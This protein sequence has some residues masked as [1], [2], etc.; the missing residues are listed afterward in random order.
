MEFEIDGDTLSI[1][2][3][4]YTMEFERVQSTTSP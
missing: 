3:M 2:I 1:E 4:G